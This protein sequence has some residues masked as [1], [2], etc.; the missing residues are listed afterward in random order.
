MYIGNGIYPQLDDRSTSQRNDLVIDNGFLV[1]YFPTYSERCWWQPGV[2]TQGESFY[3]QSKWYWTDYFSTWDDRQYSEDDIGLPQSPCQCAIRGYLMYR[4]LTTEE[5]YEGNLIQGDFYDQVFFCDTYQGV[6]AQL[7][8]WNYLDTNF[9]FKQICDNNNYWEA[10]HYLEEFLH[11]QG[12]ANAFCDCE[13]PARH[14]QT[15]YMG[16]NY[17]L[18]EIQSFQPFPP[19]DWLMYVNGEL[20][21]HYP[22]DE[23]G[24]FTEWTFL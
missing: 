15:P 1:P 4:F 12:H 5:E 22:Y 13:L 19:D 18:N 14:C 9:Y 24:G 11:Y 20:P 8:V 7:G 17:W 23:N 16:R 6:A 10:Q 2:A 3:D 21:I